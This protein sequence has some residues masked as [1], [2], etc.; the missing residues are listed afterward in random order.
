MNAPDRTSSWLRVAVNAALGGTFLAVLALAADQISHERRDWRFD[1]CVSAVV[2]ATALLRNRHRAWAAFVGLAVSGAAAVLARTA[3][4]P[5]EPGAAALLALLVLCTTA[6]RYLPVRQAAGVATAG[7]ALML[8]GWITADPAAWAPRTPFEVGLQGWVLA[9]GVGL[10]MRWRDYRR[11][12]AA[13]MVRQDERLAL[14]RELH[15]VVAH[16]ITGIVLQAQ[17]A[18]IVARRQADPA[19]DGN[20]DFTLAGIEQAGTDALAAVRRVV[21]LLRD[22][23][24]GATT[25]PLAGTEQLADLVRRFGAHG[26][27]PVVSLNLSAQSRPSEGSGTSPP[28]GQSPSWPPE[29]TTTVYRIVQE[30]LT[31]IARHAAHAHS[32]EVN[33]TQDQEFVTVEITDDAPA[34]SARHLHHSGYGLV[35]MRERVTALGGAMSAG[36]RPGAGWSVHAALPVG[37]PGRTTAK[38]TARVPAGAPVIMTGDCR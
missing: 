37:A 16:H 20:L 14:A 7:I 2:C 35:G 25:S 23:E 13:E 8:L 31:N 1:V 6:V 10:G 5:G 36:P 12:A 3:H 29:V 17:A 19:A 28:N 33:I 15:D 32:A 34:A 18:R 4:L 24:D 22:A 26:H 38:T 21:G 30:A 11:R 9:A 27:G